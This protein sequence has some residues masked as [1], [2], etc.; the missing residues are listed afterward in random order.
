MLNVNLYPVTSVAVT[1]SPKKNVMV[2]LVALIVASQINKSLEHFDVH[3]VG[4][5]TWPN[6]KVSYLFQ[7]LCLFY[8]QINFVTLINVDA[9][10]TSTV[11]LAVYSRSIA[12]TF[13]QGQISSM[14][15]IPILMF[16]YLQITFG[17]TSRWPREDMVKGRQHLGKQF[18]IAKPI[19]TFILFSGQI[20]T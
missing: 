8:F 9:C 6:G 16:V 18:V 17:E 20:S 7:L 3:C 4:K 12:P 13:E 5:Q 14:V 10:S 11:S 1:S 15:F 19:L 2:R